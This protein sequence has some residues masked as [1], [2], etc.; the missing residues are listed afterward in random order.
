MQKMVYE[1]GFPM[2]NPFGDEEKVWM[3][4]TGSEFLDGL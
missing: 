3:N 1:A 2:I 4:P